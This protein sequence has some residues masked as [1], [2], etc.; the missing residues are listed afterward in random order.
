MTLLGVLENIVADLT[1]VALSLIGGWLYSRTR[2]GKLLKFFGIGHPRRLVVYVSNLRIPCGGSLGVCGVRRG[3][4]GSAVPIEEMRAAE[5]WRNIFRFPIPSLLEEPGFLGK[6]LIADTQVEVTHAPSQHS[7]IEARSS[8]ITLGSH[9]YNA[10]S[11]YVQTQL[12]SQARFVEMP[13]AGEYDDP[14]RDHAEG[15]RTGLAPSGTYYDLNEG[16]ISSASVT[17]TVIQVAPLTGGSLVWSQEPLPKKGRLAGLHPGKSASQDAKTAA[18][19]M[20]PA[21]ELR[22]VGYFND[23]SNAFVE[24]LIDNDR[25]RVVFYVAGLSATATAGASH[26]LTTEWPR[27][28]RLYRADQPF[29]VL[30]R[31][32]P[33]DSARWTVL[34]QT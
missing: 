11:E 6:V 15:V 34:K 8:F 17:E 21:I 26:Y 32:D 30:L 10:A 31:V 27:L 18:R 29:V 3:Y 20:S 4:R 28:Y 7:Q 5:R 24:R 16:Q 19:S 12:E 22:G 14:Y 33:S 13:I 9:A 23:I 2:R 25:D 1:I